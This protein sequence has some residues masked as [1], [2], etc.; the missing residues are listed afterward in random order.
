MPND[1][2]HQDHTITAKTV[3]DWIAAFLGFGTFL[4]VV[5]LAVG[6]LSAMWLAVQLYGYI[7]HEIPM[8][9]MRKKILQRQ[10]DRNATQPGELGKSEADE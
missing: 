4:G 6:L 10:I 9:R 8:K 5:N 3:I 2:I 7:A 1:L